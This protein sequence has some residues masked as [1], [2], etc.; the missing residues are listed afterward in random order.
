[1]TPQI[2]PDFTD[3]RRAGTSW[4]PTADS[5]VTVKDNLKYNALTVLYQMVSRFAEL[6]RTRIVN[7][8]RLWRRMRSKIPRNAVLP[9]CNRPHPVN[10]IDQVGALLA[11]MRAM[12]D[13]RATRAEGKWLVRWKLR[14]VE[15]ADDGKFPAARRTSDA[16]IV[17]IRLHSNWLLFGHLSPACEVGTAR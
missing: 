1:M 9:R 10:L 11:A 7:S 15:R 5:A 16:E 14:R 3:C 13:H 12:A 8:C 6:Y 4:T 17:L 2:H